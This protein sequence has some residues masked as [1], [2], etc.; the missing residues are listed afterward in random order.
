[1]LSQPTKRAPIIVNYRISAFLCGLP[2]T[3]DSFEEGPLRPTLYV[4][5]VASTMPVT[6][7]S[8]CFGPTFRSADYVGSRASVRTYAPYS[9]IH[10]SDPVA[11]P[12]LSLFSFVMP[13]SPPCLSRS[14]SLH[15]ASK[16][17]S[18]RY[19]HSVLI[20]LTNHSLKT[21][22]HNS[23]VASHTVHRLF[24]LRFSHIK[25]VVPR[26]ISSVPRREVKTLLYG[27]FS[28][29]YNY[30]AGHKTRPPKASI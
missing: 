9:L 23:A 21:Q 26:R 30:G 27:R 25:V 13:Q 18:S 19:V 16:Q 10:A 2:S 15:P 22:D 1:M 8:N 28:P 4:H 3:H 12:W 24:V 14:R 5:L 29:L 6:Y 17:P 11:T 7:V 20:P